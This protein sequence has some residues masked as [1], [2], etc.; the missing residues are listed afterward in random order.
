[1][2]GQERGAAVQDQGIGRKS[3][4]FCSEKIFQALMFPNEEELTGAPCS[5]QVP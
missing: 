4:R 1:M 5:P 3:L 2:T